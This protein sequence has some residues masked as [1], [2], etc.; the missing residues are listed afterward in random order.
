MHEGDTVLLGERG[1]LQTPA[2]TGEQSKD[3]HVKHI[4]FIDFIENRTRN[5]LSQ[6]TI[7][8]TVKNILTEKI[9]MTES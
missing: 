5:G 8:K 3:P 4:F 9:N 7:L 2:E 6:K 1:V